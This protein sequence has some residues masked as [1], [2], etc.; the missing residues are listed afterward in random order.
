MSAL[1]SLVVKLALESAEFRSGLT[2]SEFQAQQFSRNTRRAIEDAA[3]AFNL[4][5]SAVPAVGLG[6]SVNTVAQLNDEFVKYTAILRN[7]TQSQAEFNRALQDVRDIANRAQ[8]DV[9]GIATSYARFSGALKE[10]GATQGQIATVTE[11]VA[12]ALKANGA[13]AEETSS[14]MLQLSQAFGSGALAGDEFKSIAEA[15]PNLM[16]EL[17]QAINVPVGSLK[18]LAADGRI[19]SQV[20]LNA[21]SNQEL[22]NKVREQAGNVT[23]LS[24]AWQKLKNEVSASFTDLESATGF[25]KSLAISTAQMADGISIIRGFFKGNEIDKLNQEVKTYTARL[26]AIQKGD[27]IIEALFGKKETLD[28]LNTA[29]K[30]LKALITPPK[31]A[32]SLGT[33]AQIDAKWMQEQN[34][35]FDKLQS[36][37]D[38]A[39]AKAAEDKKKAQEKAIADEKELSDLESA[40]KA[41]QANEYQ[42][43]LRKSYE[44][45]IA[46]EAK[47]EYDAKVKN[48]EL[49]QDI[50]NKNFNETQR[51]AREAE[52]EALRNQQ[53]IGRELSQALTNGLFESFRNGESFGKAMVRNIVAVAQT[54]FAR[55]L[56]GL[57]TRGGSI[58]SSL[59]AGGS[60][61]LSGSASAGEVLV[62]KGSN[63]IFGQLSS[64]KDLFS[65]GNN[66]FTSS[67]EKLGTLIANGNGGLADTIGGFLGQNASA[68]GD[69]FGYAGAAFQALKGNFASA[70]LTAVGTYFGGPIGGAIGSFIGGLFGGKKYKRFGTSVSGFQEAGGAFAQTGQGVI[71]DRPLAGTADPLNNL[72]RSFTETLSALL[73]S[74]GAS[75]S[76]GTNSGLYQRGKSKKSGG[77]FSANID[78]VDIGRF[79]VVLRKASLDQVYNALV[80]KVLGEG[81]V[82]AI[83]VSKLSDGVKKFFDGLTKREEVL[84]VVNALSVLNTQLKDL[85]PVFDAVRNAINT[86]AY[87]SSVK[88]LQAQ[89]Q[90]TQTFVQLFYSADEQFNIATKQLK[91]QL[92]VFN[93]ALPTSRE[94]YRKLVESISVVD[95]AT[96]NQFNGLVTLAPAMEQYFSYLD[97]QKQG[98]EEVNNA[99]ASALD[100]NLFSTY[101]DFITA[102]SLAANGINYTGM[103]GNLATQNA[104]GGGALLSEIQK[105]KDEQ[106][107]T[108]TVLEAIAKYTMETMKIQ[109]LWNGDGLPSVRTV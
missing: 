42:E 36:K 44:K 80:E 84:E 53:Q 107:N 14:A 97:Q 21:F 99:L 51:A 48:M 17:A 67:I 75:S 20:L 66:F 104:Q 76:I 100:K 88:E 89:M 1:G 6:L 77:I 50:A 90:A 24:G 27:S 16:R 4:L 78:G 101:A 34:K 81:L 19:T 95:E 85:P 96:R 26:E 73:G 109:S 9:A 5:K 38:Q 103:V 58:I 28:K 94:E 93:Q 92:D 105:L 35:E 11:T 87:T 30:Q 62:G 79:D 91:S 70:A 72:N 33:T 108:R 25:F 106:A 45:R 49:L 63:S 2:K 57:F 3:S 22:L 15:A 13:S 10:T 32:E 71:F 98:V 83:Q 65:S 31:A 12:L 37:R 46:D 61:L 41:K 82:K 40:F 8:T 102:Q 74:F 56:E 60:S 68:I 52:E 39:A 69:A 59:F 64:I 29:T 54:L 47:A 55:L 7:N 43:G 86:T 23:T 18:Q